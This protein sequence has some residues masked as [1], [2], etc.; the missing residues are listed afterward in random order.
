MDGRGATPRETAGNDARLVWR[1]FSPSARLLSCRVRKAGE[2]F[3]LLVCNG[4]DEIVTATDHSLEPLH[5]KASMWRASLEAHG[6]LPADGGDRRGV[7]RANPPSEPRAAL[8]SLLECAELL[9][10]ADS[11]AARELRQ[12]ITTGLVAVGLQ[13]TT[14]TRDVIGMMRDTL[15]RVSATG[16]D[17]GPLLRSCEALI[18]RIESTL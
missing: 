11:N 7:S 4:D 1:L 6:Y 2:R 17:L 15:A 5:E 12:H 18:A 9:S 13:D 8:R 10:L 14:M 3:E 16:S